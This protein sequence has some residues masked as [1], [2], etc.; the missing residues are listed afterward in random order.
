MASIMTKEEPLLKQIVKSRALKTHRDASASPIRRTTSKGGN[1]AFA[2]RSM[3]QPPLRAAHPL[4]VNPTVYT[5]QLLPYSLVYPQMN[6]PAA[7][8]MPRPRIS[9]CSTSQPDLSKLGTPSQTMTG[10]IF[11]PCSTTNVS[12]CSSPFM[13]ISPSETLS[14]CDSP[15]ATL[16]PLNLSRP[17]TPS[18]GGGGQG[19]GINLIDVNNNENYCQCPTKKGRQ[20]CF[21][22]LCCEI[23]KLFPNH[24]K[25]EHHVA[26]ND[27]FSATT[28][29]TTAEKNVLDDNARR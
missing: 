23:C 7:A 20:T 1:V 2:G 24:E 5:L 19:V 4:A 15:V 3:S 22:S 27:N 11:T 13:A 21:S 6:S 16:S 26:I 17:A 8:G 10:Q 25:S 12:R 28:T 14:R 29:T 9:F 18:F